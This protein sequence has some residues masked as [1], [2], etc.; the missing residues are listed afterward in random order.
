[1][2]LKC[3]RTNELNPVSGDSMHAVSGVVAAVGSTRR[4]S[5]AADG[6]CEL[7]V[8]GASASSCYHG[9]AATQLCRAAVAVSAGCRARHGGRDVV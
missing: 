9:D 1:M 6:H 2:P 8:T 3:G 5:F 4:R 7:P